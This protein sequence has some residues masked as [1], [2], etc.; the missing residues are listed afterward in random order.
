MATK[1]ICYE[2]KAGQFWTVVCNAELT[3]RCNLKLRVKVLMMTNTS[4]TASATEP[5]LAC[6]LIF[7]KKWWSSMEKNNDLE[8]IRKNDTKKQG[9]TPLDSFINSFINY[10]NAF[11]WEIW[12]LNCDKWLNAEAGAKGRKYGFIAGLLVWILTFFIIAK[13][14]LLSVESAGFWMIKVWI[15]GGA[16]LCGLLRSTENVHTANQMLQGTNSCNPAELPTPDKVDWMYQRVVAHFFCWGT[17]AV[18][19]FVLGSAVG[20]VVVAILFEHFKK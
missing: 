4:K 9:I 5:S 3:L 10:D 13:F 11:F 20:A 17:Q 14:N 2:A 15:L 12:I 7:Q 6:L 1:L 16:V 19:F 18:G 8:D